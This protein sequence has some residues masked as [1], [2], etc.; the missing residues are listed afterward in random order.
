ME[1]TLKMDEI[2]MNKYYI[3]KKDNKI[4]Y[5]KD[6]E[7]TVL[8]RED[9]PAVES[10]N[11]D[12]EYWYLG[13]HFSNIK[14]DSQWKFTMLYY[15]LRKDPDTIITH[16]FDDMMI[17]RYNITIC[18]IGGNISWF[19]ND[20]RH[21]LDGP[22]VE[23]TDGDKEWWQNGKRHRLDG[24]AIERG[25][26]N[27]YYYYQDEKFPDIETDEQWKNLIKRMKYFGKIS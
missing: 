6:P 10:F 11:G 24:P 9:G 13:R 15:A 12:K 18:N 22:A 8:H 17:E 7:M 3:K 19:K 25:N 21:R 14:N 2:S 16:H 26:G 23:D 4:L 20:K 27:K 5:F 1:K